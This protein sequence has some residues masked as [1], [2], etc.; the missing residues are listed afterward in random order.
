MGMK[1]RL[2]EIMEY[3][4]GG[5]QTPFAKMLGWTPQYLKKLL[6]GGNF[7]LQPVIT[8]L[9]A[10]PEIDARWL[11]LGEGRM[12]SPGAYTGIRQEMYAH[13]QGVLEL[14]KY[15]PYMKPDELH[16]FEQSVI[17]GTVPVFS[18]DTVAEWQEQADEHEKE[19]NMK[20]AAASE[21]SDDLC[22]QR[23]AK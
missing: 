13:I 4:T 22:R 7:G 1:D 6:S 2:Q 16:E 12:L 20:F 18:P 15:L 11:L 8:L 21:K 10:F 23:K 17:R 3:K 19:M 14:E 5:K 9:A